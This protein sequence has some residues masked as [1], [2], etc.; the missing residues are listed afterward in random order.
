MD[1]MSCPP[2]LLRVCTQEHVAGCRC[3]KTPCVGIISHHPSGKRLVHREERGVHHEQSVFRRENNVYVLD[4]LV[5]VPGGATAAIKYKPVE[6]DAI[7]QVADGRER[8][9][10]VTFVCSR[11]I[12]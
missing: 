10:Q 11:P 5:K 7:N 2:E 4:L 3:V 6:A 9:K 1:S 8:R 12:F